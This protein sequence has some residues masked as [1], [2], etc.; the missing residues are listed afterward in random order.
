MERMLSQLN[1]PST[2]QTSKANPE[3]GRVRPINKCPILVSGC[4]EASLVAEPR[5]TLINEIIAAMER[6]RVQRRGWET[7][8]DEITT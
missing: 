2:G 5:S 1:L 3:Q 6:I 7:Q 4:S 8:K